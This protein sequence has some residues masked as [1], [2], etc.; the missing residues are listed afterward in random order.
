MVDLVG[1]VGA[2]GKTFGEINKKEKRGVSTRSAWG[3]DRRTRITL[4]ARSVK[5]NKR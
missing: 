2:Q 1:G 5:S 3:V 4:V